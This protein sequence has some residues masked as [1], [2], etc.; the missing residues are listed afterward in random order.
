MAAAMNKG[1][2]E[3]EDPQLSQYRVDS[4]VMRPQHRKAHDPSVS[5]EESLHYAKLARAEEDSHPSSSN[6]G[7]T[8]KS[9]M[10]PS[11]IG[12]GGDVLRSIEL[13]AEM[14][15]EK[16]IH[17]DRNVHNMNASQRSTVS[18]EEW[19]NASRTMRTAT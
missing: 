11:R 14:A 13:P 15:D 2:L 12:R 7:T 16:T 19:L 6:G 17:N 3:E 1:Y 18:D 4:D 8:L 5:F 10:F 9:M